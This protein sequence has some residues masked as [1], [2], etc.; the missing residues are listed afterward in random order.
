M[1]AFLARAATILVLRALPHTP[2]HDGTRQL[3][4]AFGPLAMLSGLG[5]ASLKQRPGRWLAGLSLAEGAL[6]VAVM[7]PVPLSYF[8]PL[9]GGLPGAAWLRMEPTYYWDAMTPD[10]LARLDARVPQGRSVLGPPLSV[11]AL[12]AAPQPRA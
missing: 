9:V 12:L 1:E 2:G 11:L 4:A 8:S 3:A 6:S 10:A 5:A 7:M